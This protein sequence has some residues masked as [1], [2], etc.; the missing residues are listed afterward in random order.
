MMIVDPVHID[1]EDM[2]SHGI[3]ITPSSSGSVSMRVRVTNESAS[4][5]TADISVPLKNASGTVVTTLTKTGNSIGANSTVDLTL[6]GSVSGPTLWNGRTNPYLYSAVVSVSSGGVVTDTFTDTFGF[7]SFSLSASGG[8]T[9]NGSY[10]DLHGVNRHQDRLGKGW[11]ITASDEA[12]D[13]ALMAEMGVNAIRSAHYQNSENFYKLCDSNGMATWAEIPIVGTDSDQPG[14]PSTAGDTADAFNI[15]A[16]QQMKELIRQNYNRPSI[17]FWGQSNEI[18]ATTQGQALMTQLNTLVKAEDATRKN[19]TACN[20]SGVSSTDGSVT[21]TGSHDKIYGLAD[22]AAFNRYD[23]WYTGTIPNF[24]IWL[25]GI[26]NSSF[27][28]QPIGVSEWG[29]GTGEN[30]HSDSPAQLDHSEEYGIMFHDGYWSSMRT[31]NWVWGKFIWNMFDFA[32]D[33][34]NEGQTAGRNDKGMV[35]YDRNTKKDAFY[36]YKANWSSSPVLWLA[37]KRFT[38]ARAAT[39]TVKAFSNMD[40]APTLTV[41][42]VSKGAGNCSASKLCTWTGVAMNTGSNSVSL[43]GTKGGT[44]YSDSVTWNR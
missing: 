21:G 19:T 38:A 18:S 32:V 34:R 33:S 37:S 9:L 40:S 10:L 20:V 24:T 11:A 6:T 1:L 28:T 17:F 27:G 29:A 25:D 14:M 23:G 3:Y 12:N 15:N 31:R 41:N 22:V 13:M 43:S 5:K 36:Y 26:H 7:R 16:K 8:F 44:G 30:I 39:I 2:G 35:T 4:T 42:G